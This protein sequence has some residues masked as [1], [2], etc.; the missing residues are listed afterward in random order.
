M[1]EATLGGGQVGG[2]PL[3]TSET[4]VSFKQ[5]PEREF[6][7][8]LETSP[9]RCWAWPLFKSRK[10]GSEGIRVLNVSAWAMVCGLRTIPA[11]RPSELRAA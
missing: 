3:E 4:I 10:N 8:S 6:D 2:A 9:P 11:L 7:S 1:G 5:I